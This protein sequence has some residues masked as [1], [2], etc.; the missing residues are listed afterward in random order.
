MKKANISEAAKRETVS[1]SNG[2][3]VEGEAMGIGLL[4]CGSYVASDIRGAGLK[5]ALEVDRSTLDFSGDYSVVIAKGNKG[6]LARLAKVSDCG[7]FALYGDK[8]VSLETLDFDVYSMGEFLAW[9][10]ANGEGF[11]VRCTE[12]GTVF[13]GVAFGK[14]GGAGWKAQQYATLAYVAGGRL[15]FQ[16]IE[17]KKN[18]YNVGRKVLCAFEGQREGLTLALDAE[19]EKKSKAKSSAAKLRKAGRKK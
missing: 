11:A 16:D 18:C 15:M 17:T 5:A 4:A 1:N 19:K 13:E 2:V 9:A 10:N 3:R 8:L 7:R 14:D 6:S 12:S